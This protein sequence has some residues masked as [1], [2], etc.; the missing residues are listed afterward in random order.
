MS[1]L[2][3]GSAQSFVSNDDH[4]DD[5]DVGSNN[6]NN[7]R[8]HRAK[9]NE[10]LEA[11]PPTDVDVWISIAAALPT[12][13]FQDDHRDDQGPRASMVGW[14]SATLHAL[15]WNVTA[16][17]CAD[18]E[19]QM[20]ESR[21]MMVVFN[22]RVEIM[23]SR[24]VLPTTLKGAAEFVTRKVASTMVNVRAAVAAGASAIFTSSTLHRFHKQPSAI[25]LLLPTKN[26]RSFASAVVLVLFVIALW[27][28]VVVPYA[29]VANVVL[30]T[31]PTHLTLTYKSLNDMSNIP[32]D[33]ERTTLVL[34]TPTN[35]P[36][37]ISKGL[38]HVLPLQRCFDVHWVIV[39]TFE[40]PPS[41]FVPFFRNVF[42]WITEIPAY[43]PLS[44]KGG[45]ERNVARDY[46]VEH[47]KG[48][49]LMYFLDDDNTLPDLCS[50]LGPA[51]V[52]TETMYYGDQVHCNRMRLSS[53]GKDF[54]NVS[55]IVHQVGGKLDTGSFLIP[56]ALLRQSSNIQW[57][58]FPGADGWF[59]ADLI[60]LWVTTRGAGFVR[61]LPSVK[62]NYNHLRETD[63]C[64]RV[65]WTSDML[66]ESLAEYRGLL[67]L[68]TKHRAE[69][70]KRERELLLSSSA[71]ENER[72][73]INSDNSVVE[74]HDYAHLII[75]LRGM[76]PSRTAHFV[77][78]G[79]RGLGARTLLMSRQQLS[80]SSISV[81]P[82]RDSNQ[83]KEATVMR[84]LLQGSGTIDWIER[85]SASAATVVREL[86]FHDNASTID[87]LY[88]NGNR[89][90]PDLLADFAAYI[91]MVAG[92]GYVVVD[93]FEDVPYRQS[94]DSGLLLRSD[95]NA[96]S[97]D[98]WHIPFATHQEVDATANNDESA[99]RDTKD[100]QQPVSDD[101]NVRRAILTV[102]CDRRRAPLFQ[103]FEVIGTI[104]NTIQQAGVYPP[105]INATNSSADWPRSSSKLFVLRKRQHMSRVT[106]PRLIVLTATSRPAHLSRTLLDMEP[107]RRCLDLHWVIVHGIAD[108]SRHK[109]MPMFRDMFPW[110]TEIAQFGIESWPMDV[111]VEHIVNAHSGDGFVYFLDEN[112][113]L[114]DL[115]DVRSVD[116]ASLDPRVLYY[117]DQKFCGN[118][119]LNTSACILN[120]T[121]TIHRNVAGKMDSESFLVPLH[122]LIHDVAQVRWKWHS[123]NGFFIFLINSL[124]HHRDG[125]TSSVRRIPSSFSFHHLHRACRPFRFVITTQQLN[126]SLREYRNLLGHLTAARSE[127]VPVGN[128]CNQFPEIVLHEYA[129]IAHAIRSSLFRKTVATI[130]EIGVGLGAT[131]LLMTRHHVPTN[132]IGVDSFTFPHQ[133]LEAES[134]KA[135]TMTNGGVFWITEKN[136]DAARPKVKSILQN[137]VTEKFVHIL[138]LH[139]D[140]RKTTA[141]VIADFQ[142]YASFVTSGGYIV[143]DEFE[144]NATQSWERWRPMATI[145]RDSGGGRGDGAVRRAVLEMI[146]DN[147]MQG[148]DVIG[149]IGNEAVAGEYSSAASNDWPRTMSKS[150]II[151]KG[152]S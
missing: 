88:L 24:K 6:N 135:V 128:R 139:C 126:A 79:G 101:G 80:T 47:F 86:L 77:E 148:F 16:Y 89:S 121:T 100:T 93:E 10:Q 19:F 127:V 140:P 152:A 113:A 117:A 65:S 92:G 50:V 129:Y 71:S 33:V 56:L 114:P 112:N 60:R 109:F 41:E 106:R 131:S 2:Y 78:V 62:F 15:K 111:G 73:D 91:P 75:V 55:N 23:P 44:R 84:E 9:S 42:S 3:R 14:R 37:F 21:L 116:L 151:R 22:R 83:R 119:R 35:R 68:M 144:C 30:T 145:E 124:I 13:E 36:H 17:R 125:A 107:L 102:L 143:F 29:D 70:L 141:D 136:R 76:L 53:V 39:H 132:V 115:C 58:L 118:M 134:L 66:I 69:S 57:G 26:G 90:M 40:F 104:G 8:C 98:E 48:E 18:E 43:N 133:K 28:S 7:I 67:E 137:N 27:V 4:D 49:G 11:P 46:I 149:N 87:I 64:L 63:G 146:R 54:R 105:V 61:R 130:L 123:G 94:A 12:M 147:G 103:D 51:E 32:P 25:M 120:D 1:V 74:V 138:L 34:L 122:M 108:A 95:D 20:H 99:E 59:M 110:I 142:T 96:S 38:M 82:F 5:D 85:D 97:K 31:V 72:Q 45:H 150:F 81:G 52:N